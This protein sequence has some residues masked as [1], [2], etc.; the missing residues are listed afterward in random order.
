MERERDEW[1]TEAQHWSSRP[2]EE[3]QR[4]R[5]AEARCRELEAVLRKQYAWGDDDFAAL[6]A[7]ASEGGTPT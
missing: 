3:A 5:A 6:Y 1:R 2:Q 4:A 7:A